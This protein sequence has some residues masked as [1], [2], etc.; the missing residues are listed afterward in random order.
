[1]PRVVAYSGGV[2]AFVAP[3]MDERASV[4]ERRTHGQ[5]ELGSCETVF[6]LGISR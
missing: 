5:F 1:M 2:W 4:F 6:G 3:A